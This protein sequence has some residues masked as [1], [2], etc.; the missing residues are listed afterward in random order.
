M[1]TEISTHYLEIRHTFSGPYLTGIE[2]LIRISCQWNMALLLK[3]KKLKESV[4]DA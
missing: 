3:K 4:Y 1:N 2:S